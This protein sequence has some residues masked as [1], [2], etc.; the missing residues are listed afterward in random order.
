M[1]CRRRLLR[2][3]WRLVVLDPARGRGSLERRFRVFA[4]G[5]RNTAAWAAV[6]GRLVGTVGRIA[7]GIFGQPLSLDAEFQT[8]DLRFAGGLCGGGF[9]GAHADRAGTASPAWI[10]D[11]LC[12][13]GA[14]VSD[15]ALEATGVHGRGLAF[16]VFGFRDLGGGPSAVGRIHDLLG[17]CHR[18]S[19]K[20]AAVGRPAGNR[21]SGHVF[22]AGRAGRAESGAR[23]CYR[24]WSDA[25]ST[26]CSL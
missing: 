8:G 23:R 20:R 5:G 1:V 15:P 9:S 4:I 24:S 19:P 17:D 7:V 13:G 14:H 21:T 18:E 26:R 22:L 12:G 10:G 25:D 16:A 2:G 11:A 6:D 3:L